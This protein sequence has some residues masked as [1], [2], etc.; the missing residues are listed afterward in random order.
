MRH[1]GRH[2]RHTQWGV[3]VAYMKLGPLSKAERR[4]AWLVETVQ[5]AELPMDRIVPV[6]SDL[7]QWLITGKV[8]SKDK[9]HG[10]A[11][12]TTLKSV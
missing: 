5:L 11:T 12:I 8:P 3:T 9:K 1:A 6:L 4:R 2:A 7:E 10:P